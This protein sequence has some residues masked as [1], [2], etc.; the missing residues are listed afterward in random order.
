MLQCHV[1]DASSVP[2]QYVATCGRFETAAL[3]A[4]TSSMKSFLDVYHA[5]YRCVVEV[6]E[7][8]GSDYSDGVCIY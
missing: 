7:G 8:G 4:A 6:S 5:L 2:W 1:N 3:V